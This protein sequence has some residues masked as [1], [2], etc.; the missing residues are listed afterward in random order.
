M[1]ASDQSASTTA[2]SDGAGAG[3]SPWAAHEAAATN[4]HPEIPV[5]AA[6][7]GGFIFAK[8]LKAIGG[9]DE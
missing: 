1:E 5:I 9:G 4:P 3:Q 7:V 8:L 2:G 6:F